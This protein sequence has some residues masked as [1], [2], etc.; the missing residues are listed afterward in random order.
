MDP[1]AEF[2][3]RDRDRLV[4]LW[5]D[6]VRRELGPLQHMTRPALVDHLFELLEG[7]AAWIDGRRDDAERGFEA[8]IEG[9]A[10]QRLGY[11]VGL[12]VLLREYGKLRFIVLRELLAID[13][14]RESLILLDAGLDRA[15]GAAIDRYAAQR[16]EV[17]SRFISILGHDLRDPLATVAMSAD[18]LSSR[19]QTPEANAVIVRIKRACDRMQR[20]IGEV[21][22]FARGHLGGGIPVSPTL[23]DMGELARSVVD[24]ARAAHPNAQITVHTEGEL[25][26]P[27][28]R[29]RVY[30]ALANLIRNAV[31]HG[32]GTVEIIVRE[33][34]DRS[35]VITAVTNHGTP[36]PADVLSRIFDPFA[37]GD[38]GS[39]GGLGLGL[40][41][42]QQIALAH[43]GLCDVAS[44]ETSTT[45]T[46]TWPRAEGEG[47]RKAAG[48]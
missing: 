3:R 46:I 2:L 31:E 23:N 14:P 27:F 22:D 7:L 26:G 25:R 28:D 29:E 5:E 36:I 4:A 43:G 40:F 6:E 41:I 38:R 48:T 19:E 20:M 42:V 34:D 35:H 12:E 8:L 47:R 1:V 21:L 24:E 15:I 10:L 11:S 39:S 37:R 32:T 45:F 17:R 13:V 33:S 30:Q 9:H 44:D 16:E 18:L